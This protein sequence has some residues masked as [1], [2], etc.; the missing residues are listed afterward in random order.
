MKLEYNL[1][2]SGVLVGTSKS[3]DELLI[4][5]ASFLSSRE[6]DLLNSQADASMGRFVVEIWKVFENGDLF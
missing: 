5:I 3:F 1:Y 6:E 4:Q 2:E